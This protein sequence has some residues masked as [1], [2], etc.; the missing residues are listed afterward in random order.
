[1]RVLIWNEGVHEAIDE[2]IAAIYPTGIHGAIEE[3]LT[4]LLP[5]AEIGTATLADEEHGLGEQRLADTDVLL[6]WGHIAH[7]RV[8]DAVVE[9]VKRRVHE[10]MGLIVLHSGHFS[11]IFISLMG[12]TCSLR[13][14]NEG[15]RELVW[16]LDPGHPIAQGIES[17]IVIPQQEMYGERFDIPIPDELVFMSAFDG[18]EIFRSGITYRRGNGKVFYFSPGDEAYPVYKD[19]VIRQVLANAVRW[20]SPTSNSLPTVSNP[21]R[22]WR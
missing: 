12:T 21:P 13:W 20:A 3:G 10:G 16:V 4:A 19:P 1:M 14:R 9:R 11:K 17:P 18:G 15:E 5:E 6:W 8:D 7:D 22:T 2:K